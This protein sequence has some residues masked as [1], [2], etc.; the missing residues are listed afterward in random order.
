MSGTTWLPAQSEGLSR[1][2]ITAILERGERLFRIFI[3]LNPGEAPIPVTY[4]FRPLVVQAAHHWGLVAFSWTSRESSLFPTFHGE[5]I[6]RRFGPFTRLTIRCTYTCDD[7]P[8]GQLFQ[9][10]IGRR[11]GSA[12]FPRLMSVLKFI[13]HDAVRQRLILS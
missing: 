3:P 13:V 10:A 7:G 4:D 12:S 5:M 6:T 2:A 8:A 1:D 9:D 11:L